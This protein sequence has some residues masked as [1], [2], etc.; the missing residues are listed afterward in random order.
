MIFDSIKNKDNYKDNPLL[1]QALAFLADLP[2]G[3]LPKPNTV[4]LPEVLFC[5]P[6][7]LV[8]KPE[9]ECKFECHQTYI[10]LHYIVEGEEGIATADVSSLEYITPYDEKKDI[11]FLEGEEDGCYFLKPGQFMVCWPNDAHK[12]GIMKKQPVAIK[13]IVFKIKSKA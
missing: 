7:S 9:A 10:D 8:S 5:N 4:L 3:E 6:V 12:V 2:Q 13:K 1:Y 11:A